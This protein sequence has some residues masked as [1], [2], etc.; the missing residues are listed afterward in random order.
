MNEESIKTEKN[1]LSPVYD[2]IQCLVF[3]LVICVLMFTFI[4]RVASVVGSSMEPTLQNQDLVLASNLFYTPKQGDIVIFKKESY[5]DAA[6]VKRI[7]ATEGQTVDIDFDQG[8]VYVDGQPLK[9][10]Y[11]AELTYNSLN[12]T[13]PQVVPK[14]CVFVLGDNRNNSLDSRDSRV[15][16]VDKS[17]IIG[18]IYLRIFP[19]SKFGSVYK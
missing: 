4:T 10:D 19:I 11:T 5:K 3:A 12:F 15:G 17:L 14:G 8:I 1:R 7:I 6:L 2:W 13:G 16:L 18:R 9:E